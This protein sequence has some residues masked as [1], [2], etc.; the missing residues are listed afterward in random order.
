MVDEAVVRELIAA[1]PAGC[2]WML[3]VPAADGSVADFRIAATSD[4]IR[5][6]F[7]RGTQ[8]VDG[9]LGELYPSLP[10]S[11]LWSMYLRVMESGTPERMDEF[12]YA[13]TRSGIVAESRFE[14]SAS[15]VLG[16]ILVWWQ[17]VDEHQRR[18]EHTEILGSLGWT[19][20]DLASGRTDWSPGMFRI[21]GV[22]PARD[23][24]SRL[25]QA[26]LMLPEDRGIAETAW[27]TLDS[28]AGSD[29]TARFRVGDRVRHLRILSDVARDA[30][31]APVK[32][33]AV[34]QDVSA[35]VESRTEIESLSDRLRTR[36]MTAL[37]EHRLAGQLQ[38]LIQPVP[39]EPLALAGLEVLVSYLPA[40][41]TTKVG[42]DWYHAQTLPDGLV[43]LAIG[44]VAGHGLEAAS[45]MAHLRFALVAWLSIGIRDPGELL[46]HMN[47]LCLQLG[48][49]GTALI[50]FYDPR[51]REL[52]W[53]RAG[54]PPPLLSRAG[55]V[56]ELERPAGLLLGAEPET[57]FPVSRAGLEPDDLVL[58][59]TDGLVE[60]RGLPEGRF[61]EVREHLAASAVGMLHTPSPDDDTCTLAIRVS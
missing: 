44:D 61:A 18:L 33:Y 50:A 45:G 24:L 58:F 41:S 29:V 26:R 54:H 7:G 47:R 40:E 48:I 27:Q 59:F 38:N 14:I 52:P 17:R 39:S 57:V 9:L 11:P 15:R 35:R 37:A 16:G 30:A 46:G 43:A 20:Y 21:F 51:T 10:G 34:V 2:T 22:D 13:E 60:R 55:R 19:E 56:G 6:I 1:V 5:D 49:T 42:G 25:E 53:A 36:E 4:Q 3:P 31:G 23:P 12:R 8:R 32:I 28:G